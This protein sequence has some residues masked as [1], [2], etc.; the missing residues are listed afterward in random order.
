VTVKFMS[1]NVR[2]LARVHAKSPASVATSVLSRMLESAAN[3]IEPP[4]GLPEPSE[5]SVIWYDVLPEEATLPDATLAEPF[6]APD[7][8]PSLKSLPTLVGS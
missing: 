2:A 7:V 6:A 8:R 4:V 5:S 1:E 3:C